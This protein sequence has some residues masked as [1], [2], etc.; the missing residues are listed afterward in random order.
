MEYFFAG[1]INVSLSKHQAMPTRKLVIGHYPVSLKYLLT[2]ID[3]DLPINLALELLGY[4]T[5]CNTFL[6]LNKYFKTEAGI[7]CGCCYKMSIFIE[8]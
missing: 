3:D 5:Y 4:E 1:S 8:Y 6:F 2:F 7:S